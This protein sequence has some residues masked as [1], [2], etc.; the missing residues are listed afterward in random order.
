MW[1]FFLQF[2]QF[3]AGVLADTQL[4]LGFDS[5]GKAGLCWL[6]CVGRFCWQV[7]PWCWHVHITWL[8]VCV[9]FSFDIHIDRMMWL[10]FYSIYRIGIHILTSIFFVFLCLGSHA[11]TA[12]WWDCASDSMLPLWWHFAPRQRWTFFFRTIE[13]NILE[14]RNVCG[15]RN[16]FLNLSHLYLLITLWR[17]WVASVC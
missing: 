13:N 17:L 3:P 15:N 16:E 4:H 5:W 9:C 2:R 12:D 11:Q 7:L 6:I 14:Y 1:V 8:C 10:Q